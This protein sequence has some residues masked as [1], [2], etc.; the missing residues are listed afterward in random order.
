MTGAQWST[1]FREVFVDFWN[2]V[3]GDTL[4]VLR[5]FYKNQKNSNILNK[6]IYIDDIHI[7][8]YF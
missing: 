7:K 8:N 4:P 1:N 6:N 2:C 3:L 5:I